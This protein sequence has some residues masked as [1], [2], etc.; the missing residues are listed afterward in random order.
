MKTKLN[1]IQKKGIHTPKRKWT[2]IK[3]S[4]KRTRKRILKRRILYMYVLRFMCTY[5][6]YEKTKRGHRRR[7]A[8][9][10]FSANPGGFSRKSASFEVTEWIS[11]R[12]R[13]ST[14]SHVTSSSSLYFGEMPRPIANACIRSETNTPHTSTNTIYICI[15][16]HTYICMY[17]Y[18]ICIPI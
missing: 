14:C 9:G 1:S 17:I 4:L 13:P 10:Q 12:P 11:R 15:N 2:R 18:I 3:R 8:Y 6:A 5:I 7:V 16:V